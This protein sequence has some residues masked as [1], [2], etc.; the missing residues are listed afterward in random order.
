MA[1][2]HWALGFGPETFSAEFPRFQSAELSRGFPD[3]YHESPHN[4]FLDTLT[5]QGLAGLA[6]FLS[7]VGWGLARAWQARWEQPRLAA[8]LAA[9]LAAVLVSQQFSVFSMP[10]ALFLFMNLA[11]LAALEGGRCVAP[12]S[13]RRWLRQ[14][15]RLAVAAALT[16]FAVR[17]LTAD[18]LLATAH[19]HLADGRLAEAIATYGRVLR[20]QPP[21]MNADIW[22]SRSMASAASKAS[23][24]RLRLRAWQEALQAAARATRIAEDSPNAWYNLAV[25]SAANHDVTSTE[26]S[27]REAIAA[28]PHWYKPRWTLAQ[29]LRAT[30]RLAEA[31]P[32]AETAADLNGKK[33][34]D[35]EATAIEIRAE[36]RRTQ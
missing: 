5:G 15:G 35:V 8:V 27:L 2:S 11:L 25:L 34:P 23:D 30:G 1:A 13:R 16:F 14:A 24:P 6:I 7:L 20:W 22:Y 17:L 12:T 3:F 10:T 19:G 28:S 26:R 4:I 36:L 18:R 29:V 31:A 9:A 32:Q 33:H 21:G